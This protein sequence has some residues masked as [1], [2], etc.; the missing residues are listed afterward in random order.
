MFAPK[1]AKPKTMAAASTTSKL[2]PQHSTF[3]ARP[4]SGG[5]VEQARALQATIGNQATLRYRNRRLSTAP[6]TP[7]EHSPPEAARV[8]GEAPTTV[9]DFSNIPVYP[10]DRATR[11][12]A[13][14]ALITLPRPSNIQPKL[15]VGEV[16]DPLE[17]EADRVADQ[18]MRMATPDFS[19]GQPQVSRQC[20]ACGEELQKKTATQQSSP[21]EA[22]ALVNQV[23]R[24]PGQPLDAAARAYFEPR[25]GADFIHVRVHTDGPAGQSAREV[26]AHAY[27]VGSN[28]VFGPGM[29]APA[30]EAG[31]RLLAH[32]LAHVTQQTGAA[33]GKLVQRDAASDAAA[34][35]TFRDDPRH[36]LAFM[37]AVWKARGLLD[38]PHLPKGVE[39]I[40]PLPINQR[41]AKQLKADIASP[42]A[43]AIMVGGVGVSSATR[44]AATPFLAGAPQAALAQG[45]GTFST[46]AEE[47]TA[48]TALA[49]GTGTF[50][51]V[52]EE[53]T[54]E[55][56]H[57][58]VAGA[59]TAGLGEAVLVA[60]LPIVA[61][62]AFVTI[63][64]GEADSAPAWTD[65]ISEITNDPYSGPDEAGW[66]HRLTPDQTRYLRD[67]WQRPH[68]PTP[69]P[70]PFPDPGKQTAPPKGK[71][72]TPVP[73]PRTDTEPD[74][75]KDKRRRKRCAPILKLPKGKAVHFGRYVT[76]IAALQ[77]AA[78]PTRIEAD[79]S[80]TSAYRRQSGQVHKWLS[81][82]NLQIPPPVMERGLK[83][84]GLNRDRV[85]RP[86]WG[87]NGTYMQMDVDHI[88]EL[89]LGFLKGEN[90][91][92]QI[93]NYEL[94]DSSTNSSAGPTLD[95]AIQDARAKLKAE[96]P[97]PL[98]YF[99]DE[100]PLLFELPLLL[101]GGMGP[102]QRW[103]WDDVKTGKHLDV[104]P[105]RPKRK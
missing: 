63:L 81:A 61:A 82:M 39:P 57:T 25:F 71:D 10:L 2:V 29:F 104:Y 47:A 74:K 65:A 94:L 68:V 86:N 66:E 21:P 15:V 13:S 26:N 20:A 100:Q 34:A 64:V 18:I 98:P 89:Q 85:L 90:D 40:P 99:W 80:R 46:I 87:P 41:Q 14:S 27:T 44:I 5:A 58:T 3:L 69:T 79:L 60:A 83:M 77:L 22:P 11:P 62:A 6:A 103:T 17:R 24:S 19:E 54:A 70:Q 55:I 7:G 32:E 42:A 30:T 78:Y 73:T 4:F 91:L 37:L 84:P 35:K 59:E 76:E 95:H 9:W 36:H 72:K 102:G 1:V 12:Q 93:S 97:D 31:R 45:T 56:Y 88:I 67:L 51:T 49:E 33:R 38:G 16:N 101:G 105:G 28:I 96:C 48:N 75:D 43:G 8:T 92:D 23:V 50:S 53:A 52:A